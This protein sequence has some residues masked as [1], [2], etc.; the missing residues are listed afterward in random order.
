[1]TRSFEQ[2][3]ALVRRHQAGVCAAAYGVTGDRALSEDIAQETFLAAWRNPG[4]RDPA[5]L[6]PW[7]RAIARNVARKARR[8]RRATEPLDELA[9]GDD[10]VGSVIAQQQARQVWA[11]LGALPARD[12]EVLVLYY[13]EDLSIRQVAASVG[14]TQE[15]A[16]QR[17][18]RARARLRAEL[19]PLIEGTLRRA[20]P[21]AALTAA[22]LAAVAA[23]VADATPAAAAPRRA[24]GGVTRRMIWTSGLGTFALR[25]L[26]TEDRPSPGPRAARVD[27]SDAPRSD[28]APADALRTVDRHAAPPT[29]NKPDSIAGDPAGVVDNNAC[30]YPSVTSDSGPAG[31]AHGLCE[32]LSLCFLDELVD[33][34]CAIDVEVRDGRIGAAS[35]RAFDGSERRVIVQTLQDRPQIVA[36]LDLHAWFAE[37]NLIDPVPERGDPAERAQAITIRELLAACATAGLCGRAVKAADGVHTLWLRWL[38]ERFPP[39]DLDAY[40]SLGVAEGMSQGPPGAPVTIV[41]F[42][43]VADRWGFGARALAALRALRS[44]YGD[45]LRVVIKLCPLTDDHALAAEA[46]YA[47]SAQGAFWPMLEGVAVAPAHITLDDLI[48][49]AAA[50]DLD[51]ARLRDDLV[52]RR[53]RAS[54]EQDLD[55]MAAMAIEA[56]PSAIVHGARVAGAVPALAFAPAIEA[57]LRSAGTRRA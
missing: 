17:L 15:T 27:R 8:R 52:R 10:P 29:R 4:L 49:H 23:T 47:A 18:S 32:P 57:A 36:P 21:G 3:S 22:I 34:P 30:H 7:L 51:T 44:T 55:H 54:V 39:V 41:S 16:T 35:V 38:A 53:F 12:R 6:R 24:S 26:G 14:V 13:W 37:K 56:L 40:R 45:D 1:M 31:W 42:V 46:V 33:S 11:A 50:L 19:L 9:A 28:G 20:R 5:K 25:L 48:T 2:F 43:D